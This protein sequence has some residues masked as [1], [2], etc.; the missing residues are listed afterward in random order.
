MVYVKLKE[1]EM[2][3]QNQI[4]ALYDGYDGSHIPANFMRIGYPIIV[5]DTQK[6][7]SFGLVTCIKQNTYLV[8]NYY[9]TFTESEP[10]YV[11]NLVGM[12]KIQV[13]VELDKEI[14]LAIKLSR[15]F[16]SLKECNPSLLS[17][18]DIY[19]FAMD[20]RHTEFPLHKYTLLYMSIDS[21]DD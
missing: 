8:E 9:E 13:I 5:E 18:R 12:S 7:C 21:L 1:F 4:E 15:E 10:N 6:R 2:G 11:T 20:T 19:E 16:D 14:A 17:A 3:I